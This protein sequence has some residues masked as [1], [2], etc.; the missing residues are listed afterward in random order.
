[1]QAL[2]AAG[3]M[4]AVLAPLDRVQALLA[5]QPEVGVAA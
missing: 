4:A 5:G 3:G 2:P 1:M